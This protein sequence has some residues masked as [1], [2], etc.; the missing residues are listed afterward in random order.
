[1]LGIITAPQFR[2]AALSNINNAGRQ[3]QVPG[4]DTFLKLAAQLV[5]AL[6]VWT[7]VLTGCTN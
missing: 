2:K 7:V 5:C 4:N 6:K 3:K 1:M